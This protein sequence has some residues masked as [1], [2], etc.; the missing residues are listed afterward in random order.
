MSLTAS[1]FE[2]TN[3]LTDD[4]EVL[5][6]QIHPNFFDNGVPGSNRFRPSEKDGNMLSDDQRHPAHDVA[7]SDLVCANA[8]CS[9]NRWAMSTRMAISI[10]SIASSSKSRRRLSNT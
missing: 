4:T 1:L 7:A 5:F 3:S 2:M 8:S 9:P 10:R 6:R